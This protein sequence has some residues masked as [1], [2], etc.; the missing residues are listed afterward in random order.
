MS[1]NNQSALTFKKHEIDSTSMLSILQSKKLK[2][3]PAQMKLE[4]ISLNSNK[5]YFDFRDPVKLKNKKKIQGLHLRP[6]LPK[7]FRSEDEQKD[8]EDFKINFPVLDPN[9]LNNCQLNN[10][11]SNW[12]TNQPISNRSITNLSLI[13]I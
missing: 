13:H 3:I 12:R 10:D 2:I 6:M 1:D 7:M 8:G 4:E 9:D 5:Q 11:E